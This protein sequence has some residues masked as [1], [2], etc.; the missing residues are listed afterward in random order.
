[1]L[2]PQAPPPDQDLPTRRCGDRTWGKRTRRGQQRTATSRHRHTLRT[3][4]AVSIHSREGSGLKYLECSTK[5][6]MLSKTKLGED[7]PGG[8]ASES[9][10]TSDELDDGALTADHTR[11]YGLVAVTGTPPSRAG[12]ALLLHRRL[13]F[14]ERNRRH[15]T[16][17]CPVKRSGRRSGSPCRRRCSNGLL[18]QYFP[19]GT[20]LSIYT[21]DH[22][23]AVEYEINNRPRHTLKDR[24]PAELFTALLTSPDHQLLRR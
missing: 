17:G 20:S 22:L 15:P 2:W 13:P 24:S 18:R 11:F 21:P 5:K 23:R 1:M 19:K 4:S 12:I 8:S 10:P 9:V 3:Y 14:S 16:R 7:I 6:L